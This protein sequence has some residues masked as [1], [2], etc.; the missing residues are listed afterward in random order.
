MKRHGV[1]INFPQI[2]VILCTVLILSVRAQSSVVE[3]IDKKQ[4]TAQDYSV[5]VENI[6]ND[7]E[8][9]IE[10][11][12]DYFHSK[13]GRV[14]S[15]TLVRQNGEL[16]RAVATRQ[17]LR[18][19]IRENRLRQGQSGADASKLA[20]ACQ[21]METEMSKL[22]DQIK[23]DIKYNPHPI[24][25][26]FVIFN[27]QRTQVKCIETL[28]DAN[29]NVQLLFKGHALKVIEAS[30]PTDIIYE[31][32]DRSFN[33]MILSQIASYFLVGI[34]LL[35]DYFIINALL[36]KGG[37]QAS[38]FISLINT[39]LPILMKLL[40]MNVEIHYTNVNRQV[41]LLVKLIIVRCMNS[42][43]LIYIATAYS[44]TFTYSK[45]EA[46]FSTQLLTAL[47]NPFLQI[48]DMSVLF[49][50]YIAGR[51]VK[52]QY[53]LNEL[54]RPT[55]W[56]L[57]ER[58]TD[59]IKAIFMSLFYAVVYPAGLFIAAF[60]MLTTYLTDKYSLF[61]QWRKPPSMNQSLG[62]FAR[63]F[64]LASVWV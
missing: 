42:A 36:E 61:F 6:P 63:Y 49:N 27:D 60:T 1:T 24:W 33:L 46:I 29:P 47:L 2:S 14:A 8:P 40:T 25:K 56:T 35:V 18:Q 31:T 48:F 58:Y 17:V 53:E 52:T 64:L 34:L 54:Y 21:K 22:D 5:V 30:E 45:I 32:S 38:V 19:E 7:P 43:V 39:I 26:A 10:E 3:S 28:H 55:D 15:I 12:H 41:S 23:N 62:V 51:Y 57:A 11:L 20:E 4:L 13:F 9:T 37:F 16:L 50:R 44:E 59:V